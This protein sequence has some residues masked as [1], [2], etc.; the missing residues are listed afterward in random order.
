MFRNYLAA[1]LRNLS[2]NK[3]YAGLNIGG[4][5]IGFAAAILI[6]LYVRNE[7][8]FDRFIPGA[9]HIYDVYT[10]FDEP[11][12]TPLV[13]DTAPGDFAALF[14]TDYPFIPAITQLVPDRFRVKQADVYTGESFYWAQPNLFS[15][16]HLPAFAGNLE[17]AL[18]KP[19]SVVLTRSMAR[20]YFGRDD[21]RGETLEF[22]QVDLVSH[23]MTVTAILEDLPS[24]T[25]LTAEIFVSGAGNTSGLAAADQPQPGFG[26]GT[27]ILMKLQPGADM[28]AMLRGMHSFVHRHKGFRPGDGEITLELHRLTDVHLTP[29]EASAAY[30]KPAS[31]P[32]AIYTLPAIGALIVLLAGIN[33]VN[34]MTARASRRS[35]E[36]GVRKVCGA[37]VYDLI[38]EFIGESL[39]Y[40]AVG[41]LFAIVS[42]ELTLPVFNSFLDRAITFHYWKDPSL[43]AG[44]LAF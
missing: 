32:V 44:M 19:D 23:P 27:H 14:R 2:R 28:D 5:A 11:G 17:S 3:L 37:V 34:L 40:A 16:L 36:V 6:A 35:T 31:N 22:V 1:A 43:C 15:V 25:N 20:K 29:A 8:S 10:V 26:I 4:L 13:A 33:F 39:L 21:A 41:M 42:T 30:F 12:R 18:L 7:L 38:T 9:N 24:N